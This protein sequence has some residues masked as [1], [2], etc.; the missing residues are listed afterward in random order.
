K[1][2]ARLSAVPEA[3]RLIK[4]LSPNLQPTPVAPLSFGFGFRTSGEIRRA[5][6]FALAHP[7][8][9]HMLQIKAYVDLS[10]YDEITTFAGAEAERVVQSYIVTGESGAIA[11]QIIESLAAPL[12]ASSAIQII[13]GKRGDGKSHLL[14]FLRAIIGIKSLRTVHSD[15]RLTSAL[16]LLSDRSPITIELNFAGHTEQPP[17]ESVLRTAISH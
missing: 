13:S 16:R 14:A 1:G 12:N 5:S 10:P 2:C 15:V 11:A 6:S 4:P 3:V 9:T 7:G 8:C 17:F